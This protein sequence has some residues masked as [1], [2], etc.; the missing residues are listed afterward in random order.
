MARR[1]T[2]LTM[3]HIILAILD[4]GPLHGYELHQRLNHMPGVSKIWNVK[5]ALFYS[6]LDKLEA[7]GFIR[8]APVQIDDRAS[9]RVAF[10]LTSAGKASLM[11]WISTPVRKARELRQ[12]F[13]GK[14]IIARRFG[15]DAAIEL[16][17]KQ[18][19]VSQGWYD[20]LVSDLQAVDA[21]VMDELIVHTY[22]LYRDRATLHWLDHLEGQIR[23]AG[24]GDEITSYD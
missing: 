21:Q 17:Q 1:A 23:K 24:A 13:L 7:G 11:D 16:I 14:L 19:Q 4:E 8:K 3:E 9:A 6:K 5:Q 2:P 10:E 20:H 18:R 15:Q 12:I 22:R